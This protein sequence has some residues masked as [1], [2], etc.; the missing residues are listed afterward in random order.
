MSP[1]RVYLFMR[2]DAALTAILFTF[3]FCVSQG[4]ASTKVGTKQHGIIRQRT[5][6]RIFTRLGVAE[7][8]RIQ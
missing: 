7:F 6:P 5:T 8:V 4:D 1:S 3:L 2:I